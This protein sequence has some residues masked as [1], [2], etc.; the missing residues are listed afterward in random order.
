MA[1]LRA[2]EPLPIQHSCFSCL[3]VQVSE[4]TWCTKF[5]E[6]IDSEIFAADDCSE[7]RDG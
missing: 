3:H 4:V 7:Y 2:V 5:E 6:S 1:D